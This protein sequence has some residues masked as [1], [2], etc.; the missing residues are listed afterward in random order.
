MNQIDATLDSL[1]IFVTSFH[2]ANS[3]D[4][5]DFVFSTQLDIEKL[6]IYE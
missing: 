5:S 1:Y 3:I 4:P 2:K 6:E